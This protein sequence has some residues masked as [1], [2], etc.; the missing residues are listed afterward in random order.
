MVPNWLKERTHKHKA[1][2]KEKGDLFFEWLMLSDDEKEK[3]E[4]RFIIAVTYLIAAHN[5]CA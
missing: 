2:D 4:L 3:E 5:S 1:I